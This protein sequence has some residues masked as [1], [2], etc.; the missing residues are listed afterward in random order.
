MVDKVKK[1]NKILGDNTISAS[2][3]KKYVYFVDNLFDKENKKLNINIED[4][5]IEKTLIKLWK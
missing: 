2:I 1:W 3:F 5:I 4:E